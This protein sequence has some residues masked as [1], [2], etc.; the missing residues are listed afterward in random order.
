MFDNNCI[1]LYMHFYPFLK[2]LSTN[3]LIKLN[4]PINIGNKIEYQ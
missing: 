1:P 2:L 4:Q 3:Q